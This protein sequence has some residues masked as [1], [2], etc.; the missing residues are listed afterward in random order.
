MKKYRSDVCFG[1][2]YWEALYPDNWYVE[3]DESIRGY[4]TR[5]S[6]PPNSEILVWLSKDVKACQGS[7]ELE[8]W[9]YAKKI[10]D[11]H[12]RRVYLEAR[13]L[14]YMDHAETP[15]VW[16]FR[17]FRMLL[18]IPPQLFRLKVGSVVGYFYESKGLDEQNRKKSVG[19]L[20]YGNWTFH[21]NVL[22]LPERQE[23]A[24]QDV[25]TILASIKKTT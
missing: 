19:F 5:F 15:L 14:A 25:K 12:E 7:R 23:L 1:D 18:R 10:K 4:P 2:S 6:G 11:R 3:K 20:A 21:V 9:G 13:F 22:L 8:P 17:M 24:F 16:L